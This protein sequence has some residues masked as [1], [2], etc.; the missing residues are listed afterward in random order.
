M[1]YDTI[2]RIIK[3]AS[4]AMRQ[5]ATWGGSGYL[6]HKASQVADDHYRKELE[7]RKLVSKQDIEKSKLASKNLRNKAIGATIAGALAG[8]VS[9]IV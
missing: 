8:G 6:A 1:E 4:P 9:A 2:R 3:T 7:K 5:A